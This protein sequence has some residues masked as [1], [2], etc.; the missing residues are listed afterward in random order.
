MND[1][2]PSLSAFRS[3][4]D[5]LDAD[6][7]QLLA[8][9]MRLVDEIAAYKRQAGIRIRD[10]AREQQ[11]LSERMRLAHA[12]RLPAEVIEAIFRLILLSSRAR[13][14]DLR[15]ELPMDAP[16]RTVAVI[17][18]QGAMGTCIGRMFA[19]LGHAVLC[20]DTDTELSAPEAA[21]AA[22]VVVIA[23]P[24]R[25][26]EAVI[27]TVGP[28]L[29]PDA[30]LMD[31]TSLK[32]APMAAMLKHSRASVIGTHPMFGPGVHTLQG[33]RIV[34]CP[35][36]GEFWYGWLRQMLQAAGLQITESD[37]AEHD[38][39]MALVQALTHF[40]TQVLGLTL[41]RSGLPLARSLAMTSPTYLL[42]AYVT[43]RHFAQS[44]DL[45]GAIEMLN[46]A[47]QRAIALFEA[48]SG[49]LASLI[50]RGDQRAFAA[51]FTEVRSF[52]G[53]FTAEAL[54]QSRF[55][56]D[57]LIELSAGES[58]EVKAAAGEEKHA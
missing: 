29:R 15:T 18:G 8:Q 34:L 9:R 10:L 51:V 4:L 42:E 40:Q 48:V 21:A 22:D 37:P 12:L 30:L 28:H 44:P 45:Y 41:S 2:A 5:A 57:R 38:Q 55:L 26:T 32:A 16:R 14:A 24:I 1:V 11:V 50:R 43:A 49:E 19:D 53:A 52:F 17:G 47:A 33:Q 6:L 7:L 35:G 25:V 39:V 54:E 23:V 56:V 3:R 31:L 20:V 36:R 27:E 13:Q 46:P 58:S